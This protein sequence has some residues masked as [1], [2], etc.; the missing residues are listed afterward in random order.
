MKSPCEAI[1]VAFNR[2]LQNRAPWPIV[3]NIS[4]RLTVIHLSLRQDQDRNHYDI[5]LVTQ[6][7]RA[8]MELNQVDA[9][10]RNLI[11]VCSRELRPLELEYHDNAGRQEN[12]VDP[13][14]PSPEVV[15]ENYVGEVRQFWRTEGFPDYLHV[16]F[17][18]FGGI[19]ITLKGLDAGFP[20]LMLL[21]FDMPPRTGS[22]V[23]KRGD[24][25]CAG[26]LQKLVAISVVPGI[27]CGHS[28]SPVVVLLCS[29]VV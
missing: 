16:P 24:N 27:F 20:L 6:L 19:D 14:T 18:D 1:P 15:L 13:Q 29:P 23:G 5:M 8:L 28:M 4:S 12:A 11:P 3:K 7:L 9:V 17:L 10:V 26:R 22:R 25:R 21:T 2:V